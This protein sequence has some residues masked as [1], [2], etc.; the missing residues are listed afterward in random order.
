MLVTMYFMITGTLI[1]AVFLRLLGF[2]R[3]WKPWLTA[4]LID[5]IPGPRGIPILGNALEMAID[6]C[7]N[8]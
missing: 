4:Q 1:L 6:H 2:S 8:L 3:L 7:G 5:K